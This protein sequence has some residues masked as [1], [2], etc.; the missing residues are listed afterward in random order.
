[1]QPEIARGVAK[2]VVHKNTAARKISRLTKRLQRSAKHPPAEP[3][4]VEPAAFSA[5]FFLWKM[6]PCGKPQFSCDSQL[7]CSCVTVQK[8]NI[9]SLELRR[10]RALRTRFGA[11]HVNGFISQICNF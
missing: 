4:S 3:A 5:G 8:H 1:L 11:F 9:K 10:F 6:G 7:C 2:G